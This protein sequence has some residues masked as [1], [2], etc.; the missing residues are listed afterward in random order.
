MKAKLNFTAAVS[1][2]CIA[3]LAFLGYSCENNGGDMYG[4]P[5]STWEIKGE[6]TDEEIEPVADATVRVT[7]PNVN[8]TEFSLAETRTDEN[9]EYLVAK[10]G[11]SFSSLK[12]VCIPDDP[13][14]KADSTVVDLKYSGGNKKDDW[15]DG[16]AHAIVNFKLKKK[17]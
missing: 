2:L 9:G 14:L 17:L 13:T 5:T 11:E 16:T 10:H 15:D 1:R 6:V 4:T 8:S 12:V 3:I 7:L